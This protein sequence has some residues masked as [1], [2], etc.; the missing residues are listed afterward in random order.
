MPTSRLKGCLF[1]I[2]STKLQRPALTIYF[3]WRIKSDTHPCNLP[4]LAVEIFMLKPQFF[5]SLADV[6]YNSSSYKLVVLPPSLTQSTSLAKRKST[7]AHQAR[8]EHQSLPFHT[9]ASKSKWATLQTSKRAAALGIVFPGLKFIR[10]ATPPTYWNT[11][12]P[13]YPS[14]SSPSTR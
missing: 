13:H 12:T 4:A 14:G 8:Q 11:R 5:P 9:L 2:R 10:N 1:S 7:D 3:Q 6:N